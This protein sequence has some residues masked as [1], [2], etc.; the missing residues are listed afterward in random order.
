MARKIVSTFTAGLKDGQHAAIGKLSTP[1]KAIVQEESDYLSKE[2]GPAKWL[3]V[4]ERTNRFAESSVGEARRAGLDIVDEGDA[5]PLYGRSE[6]DLATV[7]MYQFMR[8]EIITAVEIEDSFGEVS[9]TMRRQLKRMVRDYYVARHQLASFLMANGTKTQAVFG[10][11]KLTIGAPNAH[12][13]FYNAHEVGDEG[14][15][16]SNIFYSTRAAGTALDRSMIEDIMNHAAVKM[17][18]MKDNGGLPMGYYPDTIIIPGSN[19]KLLKL[20]KQA[21]GSEFS[22]NGTGAASNGINIQSGNWNI[23][24]LPFWNVGENAC[25]MIFMSS[26]ARDALGGNIMF[27][28]KALEVRD[29]IDEDT[30]NYWWVARARLG[31]GHF[32]YKHALYFESLADGTT[33]LSDGQV[34]ATAATQ[35]TL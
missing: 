18:N 19:P 26:A 20:V 8:K 10:G 22:D 32:T 12:P 1:L 29:G 23:I 30:W 6:V 15:T 24:Q 27:T 14:D 33:T 11:K 25:P 31:V 28:R 7:T 4:H 5:A 17:S 3:C 16:Q 34:A 13:L 21:V 35:I 9:A 2:E